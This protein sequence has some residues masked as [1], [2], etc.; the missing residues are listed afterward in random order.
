LEVEFDFGF[1]SGP[2]FDSG[3]KKEWMDLL[4]ALE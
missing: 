2:D 3:L 4:K 1:G